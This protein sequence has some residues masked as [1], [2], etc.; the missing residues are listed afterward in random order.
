MW[1]V[2]LAR[3]RTH[4]IVAERRLEEAHPGAGVGAV[5]CILDVLVTLVEEEVGLR[6]PE[7][8][9]DINDGEGKHVTSN[10]GINHG[11]E[12]PSQSD[13]PLWKLKINRSELLP[14]CFFVP[15]WV[16]KGK[17]IRVGNKG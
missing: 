6:K 12:G 7:H 16:L 8:D 9:D 5:R 13:R 3:S 4:V 2:N 15:M 14:S 11:N 1:K 17:G 10:H